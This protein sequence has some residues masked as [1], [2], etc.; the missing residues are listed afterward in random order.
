MPGWQQI[1]A[2]ARKR[3]VLH[4]I[5]RLDLD[6]SAKTTFA[7]LATIL[8]AVAGAPRLSSL[9]LR[10]YGKL[11]QLTTLSP[12]DAWPKSPSLLIPTTLPLMHSLRSLTIVRDLW[13]IPTLEILRA[14]LPNLPSLAHVD[15]GVVGDMDFLDEG[16]AHASPASAHEL[17]TFRMKT[18]SL[19]G[20][21]VLQRLEAMGLRSRDTE[22]HFTSTDYDWDDVNLVAHLLEELPDSAFLDATITLH[23][24][25]TLVFEVTDAFEQ[26]M[27]KM[28]KRVQARNIACSYEFIR[29]SGGNKAGF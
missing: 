12:G 6:C 13:S 21:R 8:A 17:D 22:L 27:A 19:P 14:L 28:Q 25:I 11:S 9:T 10:E 20:E 2:L 24:R 7:D 18:S 4:C 26:A 1:L 3:E 16:H 5:T 29:R 15:V 23:I